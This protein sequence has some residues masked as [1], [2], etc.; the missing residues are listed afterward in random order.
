MVGP[1]A[2]RGQNGANGTRRG[3]ADREP[4]RE[5]QHRGAA[6]STARAATGCEPPSGLPRVP[7]HAQAARLATIAFEHECHR[8]LANPKKRQ[9]RQHQAAEHTSKGRGKGRRHPLPQPSWLG[10]AA[11]PCR[12]PVARGAGLSGCWARSSATHLAKGQTL[13]PVIQGPNARECRGSRV[14]L[15]ICPSPYS[16]PSS[17]A[18]GS[19]SGCGC[20]GWSCCC[21]SSASTAHVRHASQG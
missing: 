3:A 4:R 17:S 21:A 19:S 13:P 5:Q 2:S 6:H 1:S 18:C 20:G 11:A 8:A 16:S 14:E 10:A 12:L 9:A 7:Y 15:A